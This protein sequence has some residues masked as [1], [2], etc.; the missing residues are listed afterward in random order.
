MDSIHSTCKWCEGCLVSDDGV[1]YCCLP[2]GHNQILSIGRVYIVSSSLKKS[3]EEHPEKLGYNFQLSDDIH[4]E[5]NFERAVTFG[6][7]KDLK[8]LEDCTGMPPA[9]EVCAISNLYLFMIAASY[10]SID[11]FFM[12]YNL[13]WQASSFANCISQVSHTSS[14]STICTGKKRKLYK[15]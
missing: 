15:R 11:L 8:I 9:D 3:I 2:L 13:L 14:D 1:I 12:I 6:P 7:N 5:T 4:Y 10:K